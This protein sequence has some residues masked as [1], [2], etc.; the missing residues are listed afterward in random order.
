MRRLMDLQHSEPGTEGEGH[1]DEAFI[2]PLSQLQHLNRVKDLRLVRIYTTSKLE[3]NVRSCSEEFRSFVV[4][5]Y[6]RYQ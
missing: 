2:S 6:I 3:G 4:L 5:Y 1:F